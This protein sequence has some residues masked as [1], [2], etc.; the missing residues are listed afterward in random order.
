[1]TIRVAIAAA[2]LAGCTNLPEL[3]VCGNGVA[4]PANHE[5]CDDDEPGCGETCR[6]TCTGDDTCREPGH[7]CGVDGICRRAAGVLTAV[8]S[9]RM[10]VPLLALTDVDGDG[11]DDLLGG[12]HGVLDVIFGAVD[13]GLDRRLAAGLPWSDVGGL[14]TQIA[15]VPFAP[16]QVGIAVPVAGGI[17]ITVATA[18]GVEA[19]VVPSFDVGGRTLGAV[20]RLETVAI[21]LTRTPTDPTAAIEIVDSTGLSQAEVA[22]PGGPPLAAGNYI[23]TKEIAGSPPQVVIHAGGT[24]PC[25]RAYQSGLGFGPAVAVPAPPDVESAW[26]LQFDAD[27]CV[28]IMLDLPSFAIG[29]VDPM[30]DDGC[31][32][33][34][35]TNPASIGG[36]RIIGIGD[37]DGDGVDAVILS[38]AD[39]TLAD[40]DQGNLSVET[41]RSLDSA[42]AADVNSDGA[43]DFVAGT[44]AETGLTVLIAL[45]DG[46][47]PHRVETPFPVTQVFTG[48]VDG[49]THADV[50]AVSPPNGGGPW[51]IHI[52]YGSPEGLLG[53]VPVAAI[54]DLHGAAI[55]RFVGNDPFA[56]LVI[57][58]GGAISH[59]AGAPGRSPYALIQIEGASTVTV[60][61]GDVVAGSEPAPDFGIF[62]VTGDVETGPWGVASWWL[63]DL[64][65]RRRA[66]PDPTFVASEVFRV[67]LAAAGT[68]GGAPVVLLAHRD[69][70]GDGPPRPLELLVVRATA[71]P[72]LTVASAIE[73]TGVPLAAGRFHAAMRLRAIELD[74]DPETE[75]L[76]LVGDADAFTGVVEAQ[77]LYAL[78]RGAGASAPVDLAQ[79]VGASACFDGATVGLGA[80]PSAR[81]L[82]VVCAG[83][84]GDGVYAIGSL[85]DPASAALV[86]PIE[87]TDAHVQ[88]GDVNGDRIEDLVVR[89]GSPGFGRVHVVRQC[90]TSTAE[91][92]G[93]P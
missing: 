15:S 82:V 8:S 51:R 1:M 67:P 14:E 74:G 61:A 46:Y 29:L 44:A 20:T 64:G 13:G 41:R 75:L 34:S 57:T 11:I 36:D 93:G 59:I 50:Y 6:F 27:R 5:D 17:G 25:T 23:R 77:R 48:D 35:W 28:E 85:A 32:Y 33:T 79:L 43:I 92:C 21:A 52:H 70:A 58:H 71:G 88:V 89:D 91:P 83:D 4:E 73:T 18:D 16:G 3:G 37:F 81:T 42:V 10:D 39:G 90:S 65:D 60:T 12:G 84:A 56:D 69:D 40:D 47:A 45:E 31:A 26:P 54:D 62:G 87:L 66:D 24:V 2:L 38:S 22:C 76:A 30:E 63:T 7:A 86:V 72:V 78:D 53:A 55:G 80:D 49:D 9:A 68:D 19:P